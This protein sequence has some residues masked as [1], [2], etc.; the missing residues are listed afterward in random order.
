LIAGSFA[1]LDSA[2]ADPTIPSRGG[3][4]HRSGRGCAEKVSAKMTDVFEH[5]DSPL[6]AVMIAIEAGGGPPTERAFETSGG[7]VAATLV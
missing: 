3:N 2:P 5:R 1:F 6:W 4:H 7:T